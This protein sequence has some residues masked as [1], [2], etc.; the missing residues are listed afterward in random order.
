[1]PEK[2][3]IEISYGEVELA[4]KSSPKKSRRAAFIEWLSFL[5]SAI[6]RLAIIA[7]VV[8]VVG[9]TVK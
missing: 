2:Q 8:G 1:M 9:V 6:A 3:L 4:P 5:Q 7:F